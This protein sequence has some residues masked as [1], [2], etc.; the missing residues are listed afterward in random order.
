[1][2]ELIPEDAPKP[3]G[4]Y[5]VTTTYVDANL[6]HNQVTGR[7][8]TATLHKLNDTVIDYH[9]RKQST[10]ESATYGSEFVAART[11]VDQIIDLRNT[12]RYMGVPIRPKSYLFGD[13]E[14][15]VTSSSFPQSVIAKR[16]LLLSYHRVREAISAGYIGFYWMDGKD[17]P[18]D[19]LSKHWDYP[20]TWSHLKPLLFWRGDTTNPKRSPSPMGSSKIMTDSEAVEKNKEI[21]RKLPKKA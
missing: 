3:L 17:N 13:N 15:V 20:R 4:K 1:V 10:V 9:T 6:M 18:S 7:S 11:A 14:S 8:L 16:H 12:L 21:T 5:V 19:I 2:K